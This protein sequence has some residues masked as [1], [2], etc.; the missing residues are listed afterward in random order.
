MGNLASRPRPKSLGREIR[1][2]ADGEGK[3]SCKANGCTELYIEL[4]LSSIRKQ[5]GHQ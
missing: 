4:A 2:P 3:R 1:C 5:N